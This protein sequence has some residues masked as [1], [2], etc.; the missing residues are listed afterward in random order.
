MQVWSQGWDGFNDRAQ[1]PSQTAEVQQS[2]ID[3]LEQELTKLQ[4]RIQH[5][6]DD[7]ASFAT[8]LGDSAV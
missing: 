8:D 6:K 1:G 4:E 2:R 5:H 3:Y 7:S